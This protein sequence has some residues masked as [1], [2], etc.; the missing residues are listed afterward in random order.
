MAV[1][2]YIY[3]K[4]NFSYFTWSSFALA[5][6]HAKWGYNKLPLCGFHQSGK[7][8]ESSFQ[9][10]T[11]IMPPFFSQDYVDTRLVGTLSYYGT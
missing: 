9:C 2:N 4:L 5:L 3:G 8:I 10:A 1:R 7:I 11:S 6:F